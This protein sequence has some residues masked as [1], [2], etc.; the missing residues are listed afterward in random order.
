MILRTGFRLIGFGVDRIWGLGVSSL[1]GSR[2]GLGFRVWGFE[3]WHLSGPEWV[4][5]KKLAPLP[6]VFPKP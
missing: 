5:F 1:E 2:K 3:A 6:L 4:C